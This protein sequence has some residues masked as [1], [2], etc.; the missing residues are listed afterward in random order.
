MIY[1]MTV[2]I[3]EYW[4]LGMTMLV[5]EISVPKGVVCDNDSRN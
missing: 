1:A 4:I 2:G 3:L 5:P